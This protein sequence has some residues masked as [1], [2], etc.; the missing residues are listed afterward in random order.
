MLWD[1]CHCTHLSLSPSTTRFPLSL[2][3]SDCLFL[4]LCDSAFV[5]WIFEE[6]ASFLVKVDEYA[7]LF[8]S[9]GGSTFRDS[10]PRRLRL[11]VVKP[12]GLRFSLSLPRWLPV[13][14]VIFPRRWRLSLCLVIFTDDED[15]ASV[16]SLGGS[17]RLSARKSNRKVNVCIILFMFESFFVIW[18]V[19]CLSY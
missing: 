15:S 2:D 19:C 8:L 4:S 12:R 16:L 14:V 3:D 17:P 1:M 7:S 11:V 6:S 5:D 18:F 13:S 9:L 10:L